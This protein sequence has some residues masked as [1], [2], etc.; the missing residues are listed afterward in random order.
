[1]EAS[2]GAD[3]GFVP[4][5]E[6]SGAAAS[7]DRTEGHESAAEDDLLTEAYVQVGF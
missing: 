1:M 7:A 5:P 6:S 4:P 2:K 3:A